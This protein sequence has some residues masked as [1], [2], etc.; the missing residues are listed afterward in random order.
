M[1]HY[2]PLGV[3]AV[4]QQYYWSRGRAG[5]NTAGK[6]KKSHYNTIQ[7]LTADVGS[8]HSFKGRQS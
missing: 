7:L 6:K 8:A 1:K 4:E 3:N 5:D 2:Q